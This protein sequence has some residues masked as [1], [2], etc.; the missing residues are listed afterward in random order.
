M[1][2]DEFEELLEEEIKNSEV[3]MFPADYLSDTQIDQII[4]L[5]SGLEV[6]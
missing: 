3:A 4:D 2:M 1:E 5:F 6:E